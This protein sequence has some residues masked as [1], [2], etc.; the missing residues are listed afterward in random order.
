MRAPRRWSASSKLRRISPARVA[1][2]GRSPRPGPR[3]LVGGVEGGGDRRGAGG[4]LFGRSAL[5]GQHGFG[6]FDGARRQPAVGLLEGAG[7][8][9]GTRQ[10]RRRSLFRAFRDAAVG[11]AEGR[12]G[13][14]VQGG[15]DFHDLVAQLAGDEQRALFQHAADIL[16][17]GG[18]RA[19]HRARTLL[20][21]AGLAAEHV[22]YPADV[23]SDG[24][25][26]ARA[27]GSD[28]VDMAGYRGVDLAA[29]VGQLAEIAFERAG[30]HVAAFGQL[31]DMAGDGFVDVAPGLRDLFEV[32][33]QS[34]AQ[35]V[36][37][38]GQLLHLP[39]DQP[40]DALAAFGQAG[41][42]VLQRLGQHGTLGDSFSACPLPRADATDVFFQRLREPGAVVHQLAR[43]V[44]DGA[45]DGAR[46]LSRARLRMSRPSAS[47]ST[48]RRRGVDALA[49]LGQLGEVVLQRL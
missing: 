15:G 19:L 20:D 44:G 28:L 42:I 38:L 34:P 3:P 24:V 48:C 43:L 39:G 8:V 21:D 37:A 35:D 16:H 9:F 26:D 7:D 32:G 5:P 30:Q 47:F 36:A 49:A 46:S 41:Q 33:F 12:A 22:L 4:K 13:L 18:K 2:T 23:G 45:L 29:G 6:R 17:A 10:K 31:A 14:L 40:V 11:V 1:A 27:A 25:G